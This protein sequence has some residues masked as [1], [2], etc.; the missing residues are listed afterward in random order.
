MK[1]IIPIWLINVI[2]EL[3]GCLI[4]F[5]IKKKKKFR[6]LCAV[7]ESILNALKSSAQCRHKSYLSKQVRYDNRPEG[8]WIKIKISEV[9][10]APSSSVMSCIQVWPLIKTI[11]RIRAHMQTQQMRMLPFSSTGCSCVMNHSV[12]YS[13]LWEQPPA[14]TCAVTCH[15]HPFLLVIVCI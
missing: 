6:L 12:S 15:Q 8:M 7:K 1:P 14:H 5:V 2:L 4:E 11:D 13:I 3:L 10:L 9:W